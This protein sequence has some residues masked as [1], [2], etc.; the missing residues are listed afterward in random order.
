VTIGLTGPAGAAPTPGP[1]RSTCY[2]LTATIRD[3]TAQVDAL[4]PQLATADQDLYWLRVGY[5]MA[6]GQRD[7]AAVAADA[8]RREMQQLIAVGAK[9][10]TV[11]AAA[12][13]LADLEAFR[14]GQ[15]AVADSIWQ[16]LHAAE[17]ASSLLQQQLGNLMSTLRS[18]R[19]E[20]RVLGCP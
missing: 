7:G 14:D 17:L 11:A 2:D 1:T 19:R 4:Q 8:K 16:Q 10:R 15:A 20:A 6:T 12:A 18:A 5:G 3:L 13:E 9:L